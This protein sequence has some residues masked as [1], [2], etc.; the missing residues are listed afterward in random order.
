MLRFSISGKF[1]LVFS[2]SFLLILLTVNAISIYGFQEELKRQNIAILKVIANT[3]AH[4]LSKLLLDEQNAL[5]S[6]RAPEMLANLNFVDSDKRLYNELNRLKQHYAIQGDLYFFNSLGTL[7]S[8]T[9]SPALKIEMSTEW[10]II[11]DYQLTINHTQLF[12][13]ND[14]FIHIVLV[15]GQK[16]KT[17]QTNLGYLVL[18]HSA[19]DI[20]NL[21]N[22]DLSN[23]IQIG[24][25]YGE[26]S[27]LAQLLTNDVTKSVDIPENARD[28]AEIQLENQRYSTAYAKP[29]NQLIDVNFEVMAFR[30]IKIDYEFFKLLLIADVCIFIGLYFLITRLN[31]SLLKR[32]FNLTSV[33]HQIDVSRDF[34]TQL[35]I[36]QHD[37]ELDKLSIAFNQMLMSIK[38]ELSQSQATEQEC[39]NKMNLLDCRLSERNVQLQDALYKL[40]MLQTQL[41]QI[42]KLATTGRI[43]LFFIEQLNKKIKQ[44]QSNLAIQSISL[45]DKE[46]NDICQGLQTFIGIFCSHQKVLTTFSLDKMLNEI[47]NLMRFIYELDMPIETSFGLDNEMKCASHEIQQALINVLFYIFEKTAHLKYLITIST[48]HYNNS[49]LVT[50]ASHHINL[51]NELK[52]ALFNTNSANNSDDV[53]DLRL[54]ISRSIIEKHGGTLTIDSETDKGMRLIIM[55][56]F[57]II[58]N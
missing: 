4:Q 47:L 28:L 26:R 24:L 25:V 29:D 37:D 2:I 38:D 31:Q 40:S 13:N 52:L 5:L 8:S 42:E 16:S 7:I 33:L 55:L 57:T 45:D 56:P 48:E 43:S 3:K 39:L 21:T 27:H 6:W 9:K 46:F 18:T 14:M 58:F 50:I 35:S 22:S 44:R 53:I 49:A 41:M 30:P 36:S 1:T 19:E 54:S 15:K 10:K 17:I 11:K 51:L 23:N 12:T 20:S 34:S 32:M